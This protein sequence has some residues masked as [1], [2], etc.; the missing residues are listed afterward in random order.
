MEAVGNSCFSS[1]FIAPLKSKVLSKKK[2]KKQQYAYN[3]IG[4]SNNSF[5]SN[6]ICCK[7]PESGIEESPS[8]SRNKMEE[9]NIAM[10][11]MMRNPYEYHH[12]L[13]KSLLHKY[14]VPFPTFTFSIAILNL[15]FCVELISTG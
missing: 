8:N 14:L 13:G 1:V 3:H 4:I 9:Y 10:K 11:R 2:M 15:G 6:K 7:F 12:D 5:K